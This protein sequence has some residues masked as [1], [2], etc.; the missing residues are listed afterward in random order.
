MP[1]LPVGAMPRGTRRGSLKPPCPWDPGSLPSEAG[2]CGL[3][4]G[5]GAHS[6]PAGQT[7]LGGQGKGA[8]RGKGCFLG[9][10][11]VL[12]S[13]PASALLSF[14]PHVFPAGIPK[15][16]GAASSSASSP[17][18][19]LPPCL[20][21]SAWDSPTWPQGEPSSCWWVSRQLSSHVSHGGRDA[22][23][24]GGTLRDRNSHLRIP[25][26]IRQPSPAARALGR[27]GLSTVLGTGPLLRLQHCSHPRG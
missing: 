12:P 8:P 15:A 25:P 9:T 5:R 3:H 2:A 17:P 16:V 1:S 23:H 4:P 7:C 20:C 10:G 11:G 6:A 19:A 13:Q 27:D 21:S 18:P 14:S 22:L 26:R 24:A